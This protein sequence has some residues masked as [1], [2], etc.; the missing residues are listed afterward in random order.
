MSE[1]INIRMAI[2]DDIPEL[3]PLLEQLGYPVPLHE[4]EKRFN[5]FA[6]LEDYGVAV[7]CI[8]GKVVGCIAWSKSLMFLKEF[9]R[10]HVEGLVVDKHYRGQGIGKQLMNLL[11]DYASKAHPCVI[12]LTS[13]IKRAADGSHEFYKSIGYRN[14]G[15]LTK[16]Y[17]RKT[18]A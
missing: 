13:N 8:A 2:Q 5:L 12:D 15:P 4:V 18:F 11:E 6:S 16:L 17:F 7:A 1:M 14:E 3:L 9:T 10:F